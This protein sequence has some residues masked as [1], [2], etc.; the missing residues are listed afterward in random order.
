MLLTVKEAGE[1]LHASASLVYALC[2]RGLLDHHRVGLS[3]GT[4]RISEHALEAYLERS[5]V[6]AK[7]HPQGAR[8]GHF[9][10]LDP[11]RMLAAWKRQGV[12]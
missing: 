10:H 4:I 3:R 1:R 6:T 9:K 11:Q 7:S 12:V 2:A 8:Q 5:K